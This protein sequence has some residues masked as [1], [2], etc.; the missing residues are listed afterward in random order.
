VRGELH[1]TVI[2]RRR[3]RWHRGRG[4]GRRCRGRFGRGRRHRFRDRRRGGRVLSPGGGVLLGLRPS[5]GRRTMRMAVRS[6]ALRRLR[7][8]QDTPTRHH[9]PELRE[10]PSRLLHPP[11]LPRAGPSPEPR[12][13][14]YLWKPH[15]GRHRR[16]RRRRQQRWQQLQ[17]QQPSDHDGSSLSCGFPANPKCHP[18][19]QA[20]K[21]GDSPPSS[22]DRGAESAMERGRGW[23]RWSL[24]KRAPQSVSCREAAS[25]SPHRRWGV[26][27]SEP[28]PGPS[29]QRLRATP[30]CPSAGR[31]PSPRDSAHR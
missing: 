25:N 27:S 24:A 20:A 2:G 18:A 29:T 16:R 17:G 3:W 5:P 10:R 9:P 13:R 12:R 15:I 22:G 19:L 8:A 14:S 4:F 28:T 31:R 11:D 21:P 30:R 7:P 1:R 23:V 6:L 26:G